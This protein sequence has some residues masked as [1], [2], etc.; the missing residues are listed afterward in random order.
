MTSSRDSV[1]HLHRFPTLLLEWGNATCFIPS[2]LHSLGFSSPEYL[3][4]FPSRYRFISRYRFSLFHQCCCCRTFGSIHLILIGQHWYW[5]EQIW[6]IMGS[7]PALFHL[8]HSSFWRMLLARYSRKEYRSYR[9]TRYASSL[10]LMK[11]RWRTDPKYQIV[12]AVT[13]IVLTCYF[14]VCLEVY[15]IATQR[16]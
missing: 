16:Q 6:D 7:F 8:V 13:R 10:R 11:C 4:H 2:W 14:E 9:D 5:K 3:F 12:V 15:S 1:L